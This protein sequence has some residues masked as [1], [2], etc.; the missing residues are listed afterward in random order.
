M[1]E[2]PLTPSNF[3]RCPKCGFFIWQPMAS[4]LG[5]RCG[6]CRQKVEKWEHVEVQTVL[7]IVRRKEHA[8]VVPP[9]R[10]VMVPPV[11]PK[12]SGNPVLPPVKRSLF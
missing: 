6:E 10:K 12:P 8:R 9:A 2:E 5:D 1:P 4:L 3:Y 11:M 7:D